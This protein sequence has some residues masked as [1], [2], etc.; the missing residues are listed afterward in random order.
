M[1]FKEL[2][3]LGCLQRS[4]CLFNTY[5]TMENHISSNASSILQEWAIVECGA[6]QEEVLHL[7]S[8]L[9]ANTLLSL[10]LSSSIYLPTLIEGK[11]LRSL[12][13]R[14]ARLKYMLD[15]Q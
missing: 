4:P 2:T 5:N 10:P 13:Y 15:V 7:V 14:Q 1:P 11:L 12:L 6:S 3:T 8:F 9:D